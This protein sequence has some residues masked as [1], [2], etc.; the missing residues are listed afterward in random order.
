MTHW[1]S[2]VQSLLGVSSF[3]ANE[4]SLFRYQY[5]LEPRVVR[6]RARSS[7]RKRSTADTSS[8][9]PRRKRGRP[10]TSEEADVT[11]SAGAPEADVTD[12]SGAPEAESQ[13]DPSNDGESMDLTT[14][15]EVVPYSGSRL[16]LALDPEGAAAPV[17]TSS[18]P[19]KPAAPQPSAAAAAPSLTSAAVAP[20]AVAGVSL[21]AT[22]ATSQRSGA[23]AFATPA[24]ELVDLTTVDDAFADHFR[25]EGLALCHVQSIS[26]LFFVCYNSRLEGG[27]KSGS[28]ASKDVGLK[29]VL[30]ESSARKTSA[31]A[32]ENAAAERQAERAETLLQSFAEIC[33]AKSAGVYQISFAAL[34]HLARAYARM[35]SAHN[36]KKRCVSSA[37]HSVGCV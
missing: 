6:G 12:A 24:S 35:D 28:V 14:P 16:L 31:V 26:S 30:Q 8:A 21:P 7:S 33:R 32:R 17:E 34:A 37:S 18:L 11:N 3:R 29:S 36:F 20:P 15:E 10:K 2:K 23:A 4:P 27:S 9:E 1:S 22:P 19:P 13:A 25:L 5:F